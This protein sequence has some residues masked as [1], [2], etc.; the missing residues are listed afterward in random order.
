M[1]YNSEYI[2]YGLQLILTIA[3]VSASYFIDIAEPY[4]LLFLL[5]VPLLYSYTAYISRDEFRYSSLTS[6]SALIFVV[7]GGLTAILVLFYSVGNI[8]VSY[9]A[10]GQRFKDFYGATSLPILI[11]GLLLG[12]TLFG[13]GAV[14]SGFQ[15]DLAEKAGERTG[16]ISGKII[17]ASGIVE[18]Q[19][20][21]QMRVIN[22]TSI[23]SVRLT[24]QEVMNQTGRNSELAEAF[25][26]S[27]DPVKKEVYSRYNDKFERKD[28]DLSSK[29]ENRIT[30][31]FKD[32]NFLLV[33]PLTAGLFYSFQPL[34]GILTGLFGKLIALI[35]RS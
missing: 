25:E 9:F 32:L 20:E 1:G 14:N 8:L 12:A 24:S 7:M 29:V 11:S 35:D 3:G 31:T 15:D 19:R 17:P 27:E 34:L 18:N 6:L 33:I 10:S 26:N 21:S 30:D 28:L 5:L 16:D 2:E 23:L 4:S 13:Y 22:S